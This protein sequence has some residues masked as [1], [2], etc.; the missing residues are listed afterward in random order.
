MVDEQQQERRRRWRLILGGKD[1]D[2]T[3]YHLNG[4]DQ[5]MDQC[6][7]SLYGQGSQR[8][9]LDPKEQAQTEGNRRRGGGLGAS[10]PSVARW[11][12]DIREYFPSSVVRV[13]QKDAIERLGLESL[14]LEKELL[15][16]I[17][18]DVHLVAQLMTLKNVIPSQTKETARLVVQKVVEERIASA[19]FT[20]PSTQYLPLS[21]PICP[22]V[23]PIF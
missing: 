15:E 20:K 12:G 19:S 14:L 18:A 8:A 3:G 4:N 23:D 13:M 11:L 7:A 2:G 9:T 21:I 22:I 17:E 5:K 10:K 6:L 1:A 16:T